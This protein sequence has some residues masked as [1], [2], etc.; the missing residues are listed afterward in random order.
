MSDAVTIPYSIQRAMG[1]REYHALET[2]I[3]NIRQWEDH[4]YHLKRQIIEMFSTKHERWLPTDITPAVNLMDD[5][6][7]RAEQV[8]EALEEIRDNADDAD[9]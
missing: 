1:R 8:I 7:E 9:D 2:L 6:S 5:I 3:D 4:G